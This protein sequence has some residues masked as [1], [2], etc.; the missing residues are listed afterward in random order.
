MKRLSNIPARVLA[1]LRNTVERARGLGSNN[2]HKKYSRPSTWRIR[3]LRLSSVKNWQLRLADD[4][5]YGS[6]FFP[7]HSVVDGF[8]SEQRRGGFADSSD[9]DT[10][11]E[12][13]QANEAI[14]TLFLKTR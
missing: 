5:A 11:L 10:A 12:R 1:G 6:S 7:I 14:R 4:T 13:Q 3:S 2:K 8:Y 9:P